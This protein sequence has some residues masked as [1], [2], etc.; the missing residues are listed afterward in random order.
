MPGERARQYEAKAFIENFEENV[1][2]TCSSE[3]NPSTHSR[4]LK[5]DYELK[6]E[7]IRRLD[8]VSIPKVKKY[9]SEIVKF[10]NA[11]LKFDKSLFSNNGL[12]LRSPKLAIPHDFNNEVLNRIENR[13]DDLSKLLH[14]L[15]EKLKATKEI[16]SGASVKSSARRNKRKNKERA[17]QRKKQ[18][19]TERCESVNKRIVVP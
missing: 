6:P 14:S 4:Y 16:F 9:V 11:M 2:M 8:K 3:K 19:L 15:Q 17:N 1:E 10:K 13:E 5:A 12:H 7:D 18:R